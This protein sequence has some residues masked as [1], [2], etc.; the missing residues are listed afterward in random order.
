MQRESQYTGNYPEHLENYVIDVNESVQTA[1]WKFFGNNTMLVVLD[2]ARFL[3][4]IS[5]RR[6]NLTYAN[7]QLEIRDICNYN[8]RFVLDRE[9]KEELYRQALAACMRGGR[10]VS[11][12]PVINEDRRLIDI[13]SYKF[14]LW[15]MF[16]QARNLPKMK[17]AFCIFE[18]AKAAKRLGYDKI[19]VI[20]FGVAG[21]TGL[22]ACEFHA[23]AV[24]RLLGIEIQTYG[25]D[26]ANGLP[27]TSDYR[28]APYW[29]P[30]G[31]FV[32]NYDM[33]A[34]RLREAKLVIGDVSN[35]VGTFFQTYDA[36]PVGCMFVDVDQYSSTKD[37]LKLLEQSNEH[38]LP[39]VYM[40]FDDIYFGVSD[41][42]GERL[43]LREF[44]QSHTD[45][46]ISPEEPSTVH[47]TW[48]FNTDEMLNIKL[49]Y[50]FTHPKYNQYTGAME[51]KTG[52]I[53]MI[54]DEM[55]ALDERYLG[56]CL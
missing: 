52:K 50:R 16:Y 36:A 33:L 17:Y 39:R 2:K 38:F 8:A 18:A 27:P 25:F 19:S 26:S 3:G 34:K 29:F 42:S 14:L 13:I 55:L 31:R 23:R 28:D 51:Q 12:I 41:I 4:V 24:S 35:T 43:A 7:H 46:N 30:G 11:L 49:C 54:E 10:I 53:N 37:V 1:A 22:V 56:G 20:E 32:M 21:G 44:N 48:E 47:S 5:H 6:I 45:M 15:P 9:D 40:Y